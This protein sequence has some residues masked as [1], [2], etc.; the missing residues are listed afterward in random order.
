MP[1]D[2]TIAAS[3]N[4]LANTPTDFTN[5]LAQYQMMGARAQQQQLAQMQ[6]DEYARKAQVGNIT[7]N[8]DDPRFAQQVFQ[9]DP[10]FARNLYLARLRG[11][12][13]KASTGYTQAQTATERALM[14][15]RVQEVTAKGRGAEA[16]AVTKESAKA[17]E[18]LRTAYLSDRP[19]QPS[20]FEQGYAKIYSDLPESYQRRLG[21]RPTVADLE[22]YIVSGEEFA[23]KRKPRTAKADE[24][25]IEGT[26][27]SG[28]YTRQ[29]PEFMPPNAMVTNQPA[30]NT[31]AT[32]GRMP[33][34]A[35]QMNAPLSP[36][37]QIVQRSMKRR[38][39]MNQVPPED[40][41]RVESQ[42]DLYE[43]IDAA[44]RGFDRLATA[45]GIPVAGQTTAQNWKAKLKTSG[46]GLALGNMS[47]TQVAE[48]YNNLRTVSGVMRQRFAGAIGL[49]ARQMDAAKEVEALEKI[50]GA[51][52]SAEGL[53]SA[54]RRLNT[55][56]ELL[57]TGEK[58][59]FESPRSPRGKAGET[60]TKPLKG[61]ETIDFGD[62]P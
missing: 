25:I 10:D 17:R 30:L 45:G 44:N 9:Y 15:P 1:V 60:T 59:A 58:S 50:L 53:A 31:F 39:L 47:D 33:P 34:S 22:P 28:Q 4:A 8:F 40:R 51:S 32:Q 7:P 3:R 54:K 37:D 49:T 57:G 23:E 19:G 36:Q 21:P 2:Y 29:Q 24:M 38:T 41:P 27:R 18:L 6:M 52:P 56:N 20:S 35:D 14:Q 11:E 43:T 26:G 46:A 62:M 55:I 16:E 48:E 61:D 42:L 13:E 5:M 12:A